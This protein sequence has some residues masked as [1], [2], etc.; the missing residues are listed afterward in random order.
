MKF[1][2]TT[3]LMVHHTNTDFVNSLLASGIP[4]D[5]VMDT[6]FIKLRF[7]LTDPTEYTSFLYRLM[8]EKMYLRWESTETKMDITHYGIV[9]IQISLSEAMNF[10]N[11]I[12]PPIFKGSLK[13]H[14]KTIDD[15][16][17]MIESNFT[18]ESTKEYNIDMFKKIIHMVPYETKWVYENTNERITKIIDNFCHRPNDCPMIGVV[19]ASV[20]DIK[21][22]AKITGRDPI[23]FSILVRKPVS[24]NL[25]HFFKFI[26]SYYM[27]RGYIM[28]LHMEPHGIYIEY[29]SQVTTDA[30]ARWIKVW[31]NKIL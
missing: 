20:I 17:S 27:S 19:E 22:L 6:T 10:I 26:D 7:E 4:N 1:S 13:K 3:K 24:E 31:Y 21:T 29:Y 28:G 11:E 15:I 30:M 8:W 16:R 14:I 18:D 2:G 25:K 9:D 5:I 23:Q 12:T